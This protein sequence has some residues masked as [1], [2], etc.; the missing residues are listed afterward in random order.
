MRYMTQ[1]DYL[2]IAKVVSRALGID[3]KSRI[4]GDNRINIVKATRLKHESRNINKALSM[5]LLIALLLA[6]LDSSDQVNGGCCVMNGLPNNFSL[7]READ[8][9]AFYPGTEDMPA[10]QL[11]AEISI[12]RSVSARFNRKQLIQ[13]F[14]HAQKHKET[15]GNMPVYGLVVNSGKIATSKVLQSVYRQFVAASGLADHPVIRVQSLN[16]G[17]FV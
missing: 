13:A 1:H 10:F 2:V 7:S 11:I 12:K 6:W 5:E 14:E 9:T 17:N 3:L 15:Y 16:T 8:I 4:K